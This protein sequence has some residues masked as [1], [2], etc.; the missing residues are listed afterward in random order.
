MKLFGISGKLKK[1]ITLIR[2]VYDKSNQNY[3]AP[4]ITREF[5]KFGIRI[6]ERTC[7]ATA[8]IQRSY[9]HTGYPY[10]NACIEGKGCK[11]T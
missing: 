4:K 3:G 10:D 5:R 7:N 2:Q 1:T 6:A 11:L 8:G 9:S